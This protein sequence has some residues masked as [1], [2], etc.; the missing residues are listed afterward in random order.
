MASI[1]QIRASDGS[2]N[3]QVATVQS[4]RTSGSSTIIVDT[5]AGI[6]DTFMGSMGTPHTFTDPITSETITV[7]SE[8][9]AVD[10]AGH[11]DG[12]NLEI[13]TIAPGYTDLG[14][15]IGD[16]II[17]RPTT[18]YA[19]NV[20]DI[21]DVSH[22][23]DGSIK[24]SAIT[25]PAVIGA[26]DTYGVFGSEQIFTSSGTY[27]KP[28]GLKFAI[29]TCVGGGGG[30]AGNTSASGNNA[31]GSG[32][33]GGTAIIKK[34]AA[35]IG[36]TETVTVGAAGAGG[37][38]NN[39]GTDGGTSSL[40]TLCVAT[41]GIKGTTGGTASGGRGGVGTTG[42]LLI[43]GGGG[44]AGDGGVAKSTPGGSSTMGGG[45]E[46]GLGTVPGAAGQ[47]YGGA[48]AGGARVAT[49]GTS[50]GAGTKG[51]VIV[52]EYF[53]DI[54]VDWLTPTLV[55]AGV[56]VSGL[57]TYFIARRNASGNISTSDAASLWKESNELRAEY[58]E[59]AEKLEERLQEVN[60]QLS[61]VMA[62][63]TQLKVNS[64]GME[65]KIKELQRVIQELREENQRLLALKRD[66]V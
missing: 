21:L 36:A 39:S 35:A 9:T 54:M 51:I 26:L 27:T 47:G 59:R 43:G 34:L 53:Q 49:G 30:G 5:V 19:D 45:G 16:I 3:A 62:Q 61:D 33:G 38:T 52:R 48:G 14:S 55:L 50:G 31:G 7:I 22:N 46:G 13:D 44:G 2:G 17:I 32:G 1:D 24:D 60:N 18:Q 66:V 28:A 25:K 40:G 56:I 37:A 58:K 23:D 6:N 57:V 12:A 64:V 15:E 65:N 29:I 8:A 11:V 20:A 41:G 63:L 10:F 42:D 4:T